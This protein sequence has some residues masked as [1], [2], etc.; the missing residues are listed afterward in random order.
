MLYALNIYSNVYQLIFSKTG[1]KKHIY[2]KNSFSQ[3]H[4]PQLS[5]ENKR[6]EISK[7]RR[8]IFNWVFKPGQ[9]MHA[10][11][12]KSQHCKRTVLKGKASD[13]SPQATVPSASSRDNHT[14][15]FPSFQKHSKHVHPW[16]LTYVVGRITQ[17]TLMVFKSS[18]TSKSPREVLRNIFKLRSMN[19]EA[20]GKGPGCWYFVF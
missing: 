9:L 19:S 8:S 17:C 15:S 16:I 11:V 1:E 5:E 14:D 6:M 12:K 3:R 4:T 13:P 7:L 20:R 10:H 18:C 2:Y